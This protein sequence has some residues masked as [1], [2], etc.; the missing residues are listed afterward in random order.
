MDDL[1]S[2]LA[3]FGFSS[4]D[5]FTN[6]TNTANAAGSSIFAFQVPDMYIVGTI[7]G[8]GGSTTLTGAV[9]S[10]EVN[11]TQNQSVWLPVLLI[12]GAAVAL[13]LIFSK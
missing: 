10:P 13:W 4:D 3:N 8:L 9:T 11:I 1:A 7:G 5:N 12:G 6:S 2:M